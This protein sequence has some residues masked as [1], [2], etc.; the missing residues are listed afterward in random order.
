MVQQALS[1][2]TGQAL[3]L[4]IMAQHLIIMVG[5]IIIIDIIGLIIVTIIIMIG[6][7]LVLCTDHMADIFQGKIKKT[8]KKFLFIK[9][10]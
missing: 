4:F 9:F 3:M 10:N 8:N 7:L 5:H 2:K 1:L 6:V